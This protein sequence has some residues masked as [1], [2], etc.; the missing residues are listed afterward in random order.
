MHFRPPN[1][2][3]STHINHDD[4]GMSETSIN[5]AHILFLDNAVAVRQMCVSQRWIFW[6]FNVI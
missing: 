1:I 4:Y 3:V 5:A 2:G 6:T